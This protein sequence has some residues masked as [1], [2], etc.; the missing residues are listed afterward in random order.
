[1]EDSDEEIDSTPALPSTQLNKTLDLDFQFTAS[2][3]EI[4]KAY[5]PP[6]L[7]LNTSGITALLADKQQIS[8]H[9]PYSV[10]EYAGLSQPE[11]ITLKFKV[12][13]PHLPLSQMDSDSGHVSLTLPVQSIASLVESKLKGKMSHELVTSSLLEEIMKLL[14]YGPL[15]YVAE[16]END[17]ARRWG[18]RMEPCASFSLWIPKA[19][20]VEGVKYQKGEQIEYTLSSLFK[21]STSNPLFSRILQGRR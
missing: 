16:N 14:W 15:S 3:D 20:Q 9:L 19:V 5:N 12:I 7:P 6:T 13:N 10:G 4:K 2:L 8:I 11:T 17:N 1:M 18:V 21:F